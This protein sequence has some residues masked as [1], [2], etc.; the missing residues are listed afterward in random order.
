MYTLSFI[1]VAPLGSL[2]VGFV[3]EHF[4]PR[5]AVYFCAIFSLACGFLLLT[6]LGLIAKAQAEIEPDP[7]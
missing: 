5:I 6:K 7:A 4:N 1:G 3:G 2:A